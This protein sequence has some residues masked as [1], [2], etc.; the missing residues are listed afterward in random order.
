METWIDS[1]LENWA[2]WCNSGPATGPRSP[3][4]CLDN[5][6]VPELMASA[7]DYREI[8]VHEERAMRVQSVYDG[9][10]DIERKVM[11]AEWVSPWKYGRGSGIQAAAS[12]LGLKAPSYETILTVVKRRVERVFT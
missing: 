6:C 11:Q 2:R 3:G 8:P 5:I 4:S 1:E 7:S 10:Q 9:S 12:A